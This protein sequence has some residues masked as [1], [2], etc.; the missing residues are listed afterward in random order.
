MALNEVDGKTLAMG[1]LASLVGYVFYGFIN[2]QAK[3]D[4]IDTNQKQVQS[5]QRDLWDKYNKDQAE[6]F[7]FATEF[8]EFKVQ[9]AEDKAKAKSELLE[10]K[11]EYYKNLSNGK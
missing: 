4:V 2:L 7:R 5:E 10:F 8:W 6:K 1:A 3:V 11:V 9:E